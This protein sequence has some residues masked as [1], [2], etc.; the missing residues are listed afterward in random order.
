MMLQ[1]YL[2]RSSKPL[3]FIIVITVTLSF[4]FLGLVTEHLLT[5]S[6]YLSFRQLGA[7]EDLT[8]Y[9]ELRVAK[10]LTKLPVRHLVTVAENGVD[11]EW[12]DPQLVDDS[13]A[14]TL[15]AT[16]LASYPGSAKRAAFLQL[17]GLTELIASDD[18]NL[19]DDLNSTKY[20]FYKTQYPHHEGI[21][22]WG[23]HG[24]QSIYIMQNPRTAL[25]TY[26]FLKHEINYS[27]NRW[28]SWT[29]V[30]DAFT[31]RPPVYE[32]NDFKLERFHREMHSWSWHLE[33]WMEGGL[34]RDI[35]SHNIT[36][37]AHMYG[38]QH[39]AIYTEA[40]LAVFQD[41]MTNV[42]P[43]W[44]H[45]CASEGAH[46]SDMS[47]CRPVEIISFEHLMDP[48]AGPSEVGKLANAIQGQTGV[49]V[50]QESAWG[51]VWSKV[52]VENA[53]GT[54]SDADREGPDMEAYAFTELEMEIMIAEL[55]RLKAKYSH[56]TWQFFVP[57][58]SVLVSYLDEYI[59]DNKNYLNTMYPP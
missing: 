5:P 42:K 36:T 8:S 49:D 30:E 44:D 56:E 23:N 41:R 6:P 39:P 57:L 47:D 18:Y 22:S 16:I 25:R 37:S 58:A 27:Q 46:I 15:Q 40:E 2:K 4:F 9:R 50:V 35:W 3:R 28:S 19:N 52:V 48:N 55:E 45:H 34:L 12:A 43:T 7:A 10:D 54:L 13:V 31:T 53:T 33:Y 26:M 38:L 24:T 32:W 29:H 59:T 51:C 11:C 17:E 14:P 20:A 1:K 21:W